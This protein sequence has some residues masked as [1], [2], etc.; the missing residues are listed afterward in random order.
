MD[1]YSQ[2]RRDD[3]EGLGYTIMYLIDEKNVPWYGLTDH[4]EILKS[5]EEYLTKTNDQVLP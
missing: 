4:S 5:K 2:S 3:L 1:R